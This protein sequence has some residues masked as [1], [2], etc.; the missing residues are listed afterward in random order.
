[1]SVVTRLKIEDAA[2]VVGSVLDYVGF[3]AFIAWCLIGLAILTG[4]I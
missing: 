2:S 4:A 3:L 1:M